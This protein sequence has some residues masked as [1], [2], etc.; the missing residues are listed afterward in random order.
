MTPEEF[1]SLIKIAIETGAK[2]DVI[3]NLKEPPGRKPDAELLKNS[4]WYISQNKEGKERI[5]SIISDTVSETIFGFL[6]VLDGV[7]SISE[8]GKTNSLELHHIENSNRTLLNDQSKEYL[9]DIYNSA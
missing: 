2:E 9:H 8:A 6:A 4:E 5:E 7:R 1:I 3:E